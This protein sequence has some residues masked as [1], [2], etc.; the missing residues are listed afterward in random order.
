MN[1]AEAKAR[2]AIPDLWQRFAFDGEP[3]A[4]CR[5]PFHEDRSASLSITPDGALFYCHAGCGG[6]DAV[7][8]YR[9]ATGLPHAEA[10]RRFIGLAGGSTAVFTPRPPRPKPADVAAAQ[11]E[12]RK[13]WPTLTPGTGQPEA[14]AALAELRHVS[15][16]GANL[17]AARGLL[18]FG[19]WMDSPAWFVT[20]SSGLNAQARRLDGS[21]WASIKAK[22]QTLP[23]S[24]AAWPV[25]APEAQGRPVVLLCEGAPDLLA[26]HHF[27][28][29]HGRAEDT[30][31]VG[32]LGAAHGIPDDT[33]PLLAGKRIRIMAH[34]DPA[35]I[36]AAGRWAEQLE[37]VGATVD[38]ANLAGLLMADG[39]RVKDLNNC[40]HLA[41]KQTL[42]LQNLIPCN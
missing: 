23:G 37:T 6:G 34:A 29:A 32:M 25:G 3:R 40:T 10:C 11:A 31:A 35:G 39:E 22:A 16:E 38:V 27:I 19:R 28:A 9:L 1:L 5:C 15:L 26:A 33:L 20:D 42:E 21:P 13:T 24:R 4:S 8:F 12:R 17:M 7:D 36:R 30:A 41:P 14:L 18:S 2:L